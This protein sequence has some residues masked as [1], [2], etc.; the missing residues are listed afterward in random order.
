MEDP[1]TYTL[2]DGTPFSLGIGKTYVCV[3]D[4]DALVTIS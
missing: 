4:H 2:P 3:V 1:F